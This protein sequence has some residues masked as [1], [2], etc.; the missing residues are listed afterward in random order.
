MS[1]ALD[2][3]A[4]GSLSGHGV[5]MLVFT[6]AVFAAFVT[7]RLQIGT[8]CLAVLILLPALFFVFPMQGVEPYRFFGGFG[9][10]ALVAI[11]SL[12]ILG[13]SLVLT[14]ALDPAARQLAWLVARAPWLALL[15]VLVGAAA[16]SGFVNDTPLVV[17]LIPLLATALRR[18]GRAPAFML[19]PMNHAVLIGG[20][21]TTIG[22]STNVIVVSLAVALG[23]PMLGMFDFYPLVAVAALPALAYLWL[24]APWLLRDVAPAQ[25]AQAQPVFDAELRVVDGSPLVGATVRAVLRRA[26][27][28]LPLRQ[29]RRADGT[30]AA[31]LPAL[32]LRAGDR[33]VLCDTVEHLK[34]AEARLGAP[35]HDF[36]AAAPAGDAAP[37]LDLVAAQ[38]VVTPQSPLVGRTVRGERLQE[39]YQLTLIGLRKA[40][41]SAERQPRE[42]LA[43]VRVEP[44]DVLLLQGHADAMR[45][46]QR[47]G[48]ALMLDERLALPR[49]R[50]SP[51]AL[52]TLAGVVLAAGVGG[53][54]I[55]LAAM[56][57][58]LVLLVTRTL[59]WQEIGS[60]L[61][62]NVVLLVAAS[63]ALGDALGVTG[64][65]TFLAHA[66]VAV[67][68]AMPPAWAL[69]AL[70]GLMGL[71]TNFV[72]NNA[73]AAVGTPLAVEVARALGVPPE[74][75]V[76][77]VLFGC[78]LCYVT[79][80]AYQTNLL[81]MN[82]A[83]YTFR[84][85]VRVGAPLFVL[86]WV[87]LS[88]LLAR[89]YGL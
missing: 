68:D 9:H 16:M 87:A 48:V 7:D 83:G 34:E 24:V 42:N 73:A 74:P 59:A 5:L 6:L 78:N 47:D 2:W 43:D 28:R 27:G 15:V 79:P 66:L 49:R 33:L 23:V 18:A 38:L 56:V 61:S 13:R 19:M 17:L 26:G 55:A 21:A 53:M 54:P 65:T 1:F 51:V 52:L 4:F 39:K 62:V 71:L 14:G 3:L 29:I 69:A 57:G 30:L 20:M 11:C 44:G 37:T 40:R 35:L 50:K 8:V 77:A 84:D 76:L 58:V 80:M 88:V 41:D 63:L 46:L 75:F 64:G 12:M 72:S 70:M 32:V 45:L 85:F 82:V 67:V 86:M 31:P 89:H 81:V 25:P 22:T 36:D 60:A 10:P